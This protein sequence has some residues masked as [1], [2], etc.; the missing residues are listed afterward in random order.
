MRKGKKRLV[1]RILASLMTIVMAVQNPA[2]AFAAGAANGNKSTQEFENWEEMVVEIAKSEEGILADN[3]ELFAGYFQKKVDETTGYGIAQYG[4]QAREELSSIQKEIYDELKQQIIKVAAGQISST[5]FTIS[6]P[7]CNQVN[8]IGSDLVV[9]GNFTEEAKASFAEE[10]EKSVGAKTLMH[11]LLADLPY[12]MYWFDKTIG[13]NVSYGYSGNR[14]QIT[15]KEYTF[16]FAVAKE[17][18]LDNMKQTTETD[19]AKTS[20]TTNTL[21]KAEEVVASFADD[22]DITKL[23]K[24]KEWIC[25]ATS[26]NSD[27]AD[28]KAD[29][30]YGNPWQVIYVFDEDLSTKVVC[31][32]YSKAFQLLCDLTKWEGDVVSY[33]VSG[34][35]NDGAHMWNVLTI[36]GDNYLVD[37]T[38]SDEGAVGK[39]GGLFLDTE[40][41][42]SAKDHSWYSLSVGGQS[43]TYVY[44]EEQKDLYCDGYLELAIFEQ[45]VVALDSITKVYDGN[46]QINEVAFVSKSSGKPLLLREG[47]DY[48]LEDACFCDV[49]TENEDANAGTKKLK[50]NVNL[51]FVG[52]KKVIF[53]NKAT[54]CS[55][56]GKVGTIT[57]CPVTIKNPTLYINYDDTTYFG[58]LLSD[59]APNHKGVTVSGKLTVVSTEGDT[60]LFEVIPDS[61]KI[62]YQLK[63]G[64]TAEAQG[65]K[66]TVKMKFQPDN[67][68]YAAADSALTIEVT[69]KTVRNDVP[70]S[71]EKS[72]TY[73]NV[74]ELIK[75]Q[76]V[77][78]RKYTSDDG[79]G[80]YRIISTNEKSREV[81]YVSPANK[82]TLSVII[83]VVVVISGKS[84]KVT[85]IEKKA[86]QNLKIKK[87][88]IGKNVKKIGA[89]AFYRCSKV[90][91]ITIKTTKLKLKSIGSKAFAKTPKKVTV[92]LPKKK[93]KNY[94]KILIKRGI[95]KK[96]KFKK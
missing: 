57:L 28:D 41:T 43:I 72:T 19:V 75:A 77:K 37:V 93:F 59:F 53:E 88:T 91:T 30:P 26:Y 1:V 87:I 38:N 66:M 50:G 45:E 55:L 60:D 90:K 81:S 54:I 73:E 47:V 34:T 20:A 65:K 69:K 80:V 89:K 71:L 48:H 15:L 40:I 84:Y 56:T 68:N 94:K 12:E 35:M 31:E 92:K 76:P 39:E 25:Q 70:S 62:G 24:Y 79:S 14:T 86:L 42:S 95:Y 9:D 52:R 11:A 3:E 36:D 33:C 5:K 51:T 64:L 17:Y 85:Q 16:S 32:G 96:A 58:I 22:T 7:I 46:A 18:A 44:D 13:M 29:T 8:I 23:E 2:L 27:A 61:Q 67:R 63:N 4:T 10:V 21:Q 6:G 74:G 49:S 83:P 78:G 82:K